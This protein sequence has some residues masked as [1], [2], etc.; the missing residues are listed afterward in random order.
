MRF[1]T[2]KEIK[3]LPKDK[4]A[5]HKDNLCKNLYININPSQSGNASLTFYFRYTKNQ[6]IHNIRL[7]K[8][9]AIS[10]AQARFKASELNLKLNENAPLNNG[11]NKTIKE[12]FDEWLSVNPAKFKPLELH[13]INRYPNIKLKDIKKHDILTMLDLLYKQGKKETLRR[14]YSKLKAFLTYCIN[15]DY[16]NADCYQNLINID[17]NSLYG[18]AE[19]TPLRAITDK[20]L[21]KSFL[22]A[23]DDHKGSV[24]VKIALKISTHIFLRDKTL[25]NLRWQYIDFNKKIIRIPSHLMKS[26]EE[27]IIPLTNNVIK[28]FKELQPYTIPS[29]YCFPSDTNKSKCL[30][31]N[32]LNQAIKRLGYGD[33]MVFHGLRTT[34]STFLYENKKEHKQDSEVIELCLDHRER[35]KIKA[36]YN[37]SKRLDDR[38]ELMQWW[39]DFLENL[40]S[41]T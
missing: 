31:E 9:P 24:I 19:S 20:E 37:R 4:R 27:F 40:A 12:L 21:F 34:A 25:R 10:L 18:K 13:F 3:G 15:R 8:Y 30:S 39:S 26:K 36:V 32:T 14:V 28:L 11:S 17:I 2:D 6:K 33:L 5:Y 1:S 23:I 29:E 35:N 41:E 16:I 38:K 22:Q 7:G